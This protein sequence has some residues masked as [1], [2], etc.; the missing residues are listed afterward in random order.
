MEIQEVIQTIITGITA[1]FTYIISKKY[2]FKYIIQFIEWLFNFKKDFD[3]KN[4]DASKELLE[5]KDSSNNVYENQIIFLTEQVKTFEERI[6]FKQNEL[7][8]YLD[9]LS[10]LRQKILVLQK[11]V[12]NNQVQ[13]AQLKSMYCGNISCQARINCD[14]CSIEH[15]RK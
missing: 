4:V 12:Y 2:L 15:R 11:D 1:I 13:I 3:K 14:N 10:E 5:I 6:N 9:E 7:N 8:K